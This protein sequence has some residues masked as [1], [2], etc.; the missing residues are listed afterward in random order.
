M[1]PGAGREDRP[2]GAGPAGPAGTDPGP[3][4]AAQQ[5]GTPGRGVVEHS[6]NLLDHLEIDVKHNGTSHFTELLEPMDLNGVAVTFDALHTVRANLDQLVTT[7]HGRYVAVVK[8]NQPL[9]YVSTPG[10]N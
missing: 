8:K 10:Q 1:L 4:R 9:L 2:H 7:E 3:A 6:G 5:P